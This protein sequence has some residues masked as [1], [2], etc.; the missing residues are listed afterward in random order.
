MKGL[1]AGRKASGHVR[2]ALERRMGAGFASRSGGA[3]LQAP[4]LAFPGQIRAY[5]DPFIPGRGGLFLPLLQS[6]RLFR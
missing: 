4:L 3:R 5:A 2:R 1:L 6:H